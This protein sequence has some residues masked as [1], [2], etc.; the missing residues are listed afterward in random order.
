[1]LSWGLSL[2]YLVHKYAKFELLILFFNLYVYCRNHFNFFV[3]AD[4]RNHPILIHCKRGKVKESHWRTSNSFKC[5]E[6]LM[7][8]HSFICK[9]SSSI[10]QGVLWAVSESYRTGACLLCLR[11]II[12]LLP[13][14]LDHQIWVL[15]VSSTSHARCV[16]SVSSTGA[17]DVV[18]KLGA[19]FTRIIIARHDEQSLLFLFYFSYHVV[20][21]W[22]SNIPLQ[23]CSCTSFSYRNINNLLTLFFRCQGNSSR[24]FVVPLEAIICYNFIC[25]L[26]NFIGWERWITACM[27]LRSRLAVVTC[28]P[29]VTQ[30]M[31]FTLR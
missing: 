23:I 16:Y 19:C 9:W 7:N 5:L 2:S 13:P 29:N 26:L 6:L 3:L 12:A 27:H 30:D 10:G 31:L 8:L 17:M 24:L 22:K 21:S 1:M 25:Y 4:V 20:L 14:K 15:S 18:P 11:S 28:N